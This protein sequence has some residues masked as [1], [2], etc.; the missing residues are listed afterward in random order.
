MV[1]G[2]FAQYWDSMAV[3]FRISVTR[4]RSGLRIEYMDR[5]VE[6]A[7]W[8]SRDCS[9]R[10]CCANKLSCTGQDGTAGP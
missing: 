1:D 5:H 2:S 7:G 4:V 10:R 3:S 9:C 6:P 8:H